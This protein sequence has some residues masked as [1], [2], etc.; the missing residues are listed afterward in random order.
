VLFAAIAGYGFAVAIASLGT[1][2]AGAIFDSPPAGQPAT[3]YLA[4]SI[5][6]GFLGALGGGYLC[7]RVAPENT[8]LIAM[9]LLVLLFLGMAVA[10]ARWGPSDPGP[11]PSV[12]PLVTM[13]GVVGAWAGAMVERAIHAPVISRASSRE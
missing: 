13:L 2:I 9:A 8:R 5:A 7:C 3:A 12:L 6:I 1:F 4:I 10:T 11:P